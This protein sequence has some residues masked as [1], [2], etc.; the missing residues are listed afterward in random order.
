MSIDTTFLLSFLISPY[1]RFGE[2]ILRAWI[3][4]YIETLPRFQWSFLPSHN[5][6]SPLHKLMKEVIF[7]VQMLRSWTHFRYVGHFDGAHV[8]FKYSAFHHWSV[9]FLD[10][11]RLWC[12]FCQGIKGK[13]SCA[14][15]D[16]AMYSTLVTDNAIS[17]CILDVHTTGYTANWITYPVL[18]HAVDGSSIAVACFQSPACEAST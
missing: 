15:N 11:L 16:S 10:Y 17:V 4:V 5:Q 3:Y 6:N 9:N 18:D 13:I 1:K 12:F 8:I 14:A 7:D 2:N